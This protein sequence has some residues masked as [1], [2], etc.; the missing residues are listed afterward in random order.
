MKYIKNKKYAF[1]LVELIIV[2]TILAI[3]ATI[4]FISFKNYSKSS[5]DTNRVSTLK[6]MEKWL[7]I[8]ALKIWKYPNPE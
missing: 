6:N 1:T 3:L 7:D 5:R 4:S 2:I 8:F